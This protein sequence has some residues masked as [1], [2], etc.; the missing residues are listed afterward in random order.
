VKNQFT[1]DGD[2]AHIQLFYRGGFV[3]T[4]VDAEDLPRLMELG[5]TWSVK[6][7][8]KQRCFRPICRMDGKTTYLYRFLIDVPHDC[9][10]DHINHNTL[11]NRKANLRAVK[12]NENSR[13]R[14]GADIDS[15]S[16]V[17]NVYWDTARSKWGVSLRKDGRHHHF[18]YFTDI[19]RAASV[20]EIAR[21]EV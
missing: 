8:Q 3:T 1:V 16:G 4:M 10:V 15:K 7:Y 17:R 14:S 19:D 6:Y 20:A 5:L 11:D 13:N 12:P 9:H 2:I 18:G 21:Q